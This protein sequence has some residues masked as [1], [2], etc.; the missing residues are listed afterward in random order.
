MITG[1]QN[2]YYRVF[3][4]FDAQWGGTIFIEF[5]LIIILQTLNEIE[6]P[7]TPYVPLDDC[8]LAAIQAKAKI[9]RSQLATIL[10]SSP[11]KI[12]YHLKS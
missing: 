4:A 6:I 3:T 2:E 9:S 8:I 10:N 12:K 5:I 7:D 1:H 11:E